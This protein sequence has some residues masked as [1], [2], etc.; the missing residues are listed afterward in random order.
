[1]V[2]EGVPSRCNGRMDLDEIKVGIQM[3]YNLDFFAAF[4]GFC[5]APIQIASSETRTYHYYI[6]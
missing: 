3:D 2:T 1:M 5:F 6:N 4:F